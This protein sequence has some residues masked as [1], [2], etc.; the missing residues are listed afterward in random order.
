MLDMLKFLVSVGNVHCPNSKMLV[1]TKMMLVHV[2]IDL[3]GHSY[4]V[5]DMWN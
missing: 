2:G 3:L 1:E 5:K 4:Q